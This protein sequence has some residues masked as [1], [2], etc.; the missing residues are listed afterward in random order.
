MEKKFYHTNT[1]PSRIDRELERLIGLLQAPD[2][3]RASVI[4]SINELSSRRT[5]L[6]RPGIVRRT[7][8]LPENSPLKNY[9][10]DTRLKVFAAQSGGAETDE[11]IS[12]GLRAI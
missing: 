3:D 2:A 6:M 9:L 1:D 7:R 8:R 12:Y 10:D 5:R 4:A 11:D